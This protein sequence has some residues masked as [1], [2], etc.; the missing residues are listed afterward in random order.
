MSSSSRPYKRR[1]IVVKK[2]FQY[3]FVAWMVGTVLAAV[4]VMLV[5]VFVSV[6][7]HLAEGDTAVSWTDIYNPGHPVTVAKLILFLAGVFIASLVLS[8]RVAGPIYRF[9]RSADEV[10]GGDLTS[11]VFLRDRDEL[12]DFRNVFN[13]MVDALRNRVAG[14]VACAFRA[15]KVLEEA[16]KDGSLSQEA[17]AQIRKAV[18]EVDKVGKS[19]KI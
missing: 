18:T 17:S 9:E 12:G 7:Q 2:S 19:F 13:T 15:K 1:I 8:H 14:D 3:R 11:R 10:A 16:L 6:Q 4:V 5:D